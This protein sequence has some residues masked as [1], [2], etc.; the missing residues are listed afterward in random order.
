MHKTSNGINDHMSVQI[1]GTIS[2]AIYV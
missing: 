2:K 1:N